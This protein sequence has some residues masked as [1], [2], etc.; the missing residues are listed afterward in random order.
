[1]VPDS[2]VK[3]RRWWG[4]LLVLC[5]EPLVALY[6]F[7][8]LLLCDRTEEDVVDHVGSDLWFP[9]RQTDSL[10]ILFQL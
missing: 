8:C 9:E 3:L 10:N 7:D 5:D 4:N 2:D 6:V 1:M